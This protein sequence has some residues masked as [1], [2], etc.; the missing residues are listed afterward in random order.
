MQTG[1]FM[2]IDVNFW[3]SV[4]TLVSLVLFLALVAWTWSRRR[5]PAH[6]EAAQL[7]FLDAE[8]ANAS[9]DKN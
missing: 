9:A 4:V 2:D 5:L 1:A 7:P 8:P 6:D 3:R